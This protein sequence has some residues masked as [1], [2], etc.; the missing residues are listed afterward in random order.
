MR[1][2]SFRVG[3]IPV[4]VEP[5]F[6]LVA[7]VLGMYLEPRYLTA[8]V[9]AVFLGVLV[10]ELGHALVGRSYGLTPSISLYG[11]GGVTSWRN[12]QRLDTWRSVWLSLAGP[13]AG[14]GLGLA[15]WVIA[16][17]VPLP[18]VGWW[19]YALVYFGM[20]VNFGW[21]LLN[22][23]P[24]L[25][26]DGGNIMRVLVRRYVLRPAS[27]L[28]LQISVAVAACTALAG[29]VWGQFGLAM[30]F[31]WLAYLNYLS[32]QRAGPGGLMR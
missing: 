27:Q 1:S 17:L 8:W 26:L 32:L 16:T 9:P 31:G 24:V 19:A 5:W 3:G 13:M 4:T 21:G 25:P 28:P 11:L 10:H 6:W 12:T 30:L 22:L 23:L 2:W 15:L 20:Y 14:F 7:V 18:S 29:A